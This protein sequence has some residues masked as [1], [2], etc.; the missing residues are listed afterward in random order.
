MRNR[1]ESET[2]PADIG[3]RAI[4][5]IIDTVIFGV[6]ALMLILILGGVLSVTGA[7]DETIEQTTTILALALLALYLLYFIVLEGKYGS[8][9]GKKVMKLR[10][11][12]LEGR[13]ISWREAIIRN[14]FRG[15]DILFFYLV[16][17]L[18]I[19]LTAKSQRVGDLAANTIVVPAL[20]A[21]S[22]DEYDPE[23]G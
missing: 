10:V 3:P 13:P 23:I 11:A 5:H 2:Q 16:G 4:A 21:T 22:E 14:V 6:I 15:L 18:F 20:P 7:G 19:V 1:Q 12:T 17:L 9:V 8:T